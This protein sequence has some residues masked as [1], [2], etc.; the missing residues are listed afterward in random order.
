MSNKNY[1]IFGKILSILNNDCPP[2]VSKTF[3]DNVIKDI[4]KN[5]SLLYKYKNFLNIAAS[6]FFAVITAYG[7]ISF[8]Q[9]EQNIIAEEKIDEENSLIKRVIDDSSCNKLK[10]QE[11][12]K[13]DKCE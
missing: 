9:T 2:Y 6:V 1:I 12:N 11:G 10:N 3:S 7:L 8:Q 5:R 4:N 13:N